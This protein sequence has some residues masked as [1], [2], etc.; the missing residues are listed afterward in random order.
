MTEV[1][2]ISPALTKWLA[3]SI[4][5][6]KISIKEIDI[7]INTSQFTD[8]FDPL[9]DK[10]K[11]YPTNQ[12]WV[13]LSKE[14]GLTKRQYT[15]AAK[16]VFNGWISGSMAG[17]RKRFFHKNLRKR[18]IC[19]HEFGEC[20]IGAATKSSKSGFK[21]QFLNKKG[22][23]AYVHHVGL[24]ANSCCKK[25]IH[26]LKV[27]KAIPHKKSEPD[28]LSISHL[29]GNGGCARPGHYKVELKKTNDERTH[30]HFLLRRA[31]SLKDSRA[32]R[33]ACPHT[34]KCFVNIY[35]TNKA[36]F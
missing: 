33:R 26:P 15:K 11:Y 13:P 5:T 35:L 32:I 27:L 20:L 1:I 28:S 18:K 17:K 23:D 6:R 4:N 12:T 19:F 29:C 3:G 34:P 25:P 22:S 10:V 36:Y 30:C 21:V 2:P 24:F 8:G 7:K 9:V 31:K 16:Q 14:E